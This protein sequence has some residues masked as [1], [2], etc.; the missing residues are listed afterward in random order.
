METKCYANLPL[1]FNRV[2]HFLNQLGKLKALKSQQKE[3]EFL[4]L[5]DTLFKEHSPSDY[6][7]AQEA[8]EVILN[9]LYYDR[10]ARG[11]RGGSTKM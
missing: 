2:G 8:Y 1:L 5:F 10:E 11:C 3:K 6:D 7:A 9:T 4:K